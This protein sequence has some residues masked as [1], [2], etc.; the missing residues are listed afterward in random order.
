[1]VNLSTL[2]EFF[3]NWILAL[4]ELWDFFNTPLSYSLEPLMLSFPP[5]AVV[6]GILSI[7]GLYDLTLIEFAF[8]VGLVTVITLKL[9]KFFLS[10]IP[11]LY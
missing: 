11:F 9:I 3:T 10:F 2:I 8:S 4:G 6:N 1:M 7:L 5:F